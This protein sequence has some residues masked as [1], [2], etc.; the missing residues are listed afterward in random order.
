MKSDFVAIDFETANNERSSACAIGL[1]RIAN[2]EIV[3]KESRLINPHTY[4]H[5]FCIDVHGLTE[6]DVEDALA[7]DEVWQE[8]V[9]MLKEADFIVAHN[10]SFDK[11]VL[12]KSCE[13][14]NIPIPKHKITC[15]I[16]AAKSFLKLPSYSLDEVC[17]HLGIELDHHEALSDAMG[18][19]QIMIKALE[20]GYKV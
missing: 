9:P 7:F 15:S 10:A 3:A 16:K 17:E 5:S 1:V 13:K 4:F 12:Y 20:Q 8:L 11:S 6:E 2:G 18:C 19:A 14:Y